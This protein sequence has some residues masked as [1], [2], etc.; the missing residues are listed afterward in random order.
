MFCVCFFVSQSVFAYE[1]ARRT[2]NYGAEQKR[3]DAIAPLGIPFSGFDFF[4]FFGV[5][6]EFNDNIVKSEVLVLDDF[7]THLSP[8]FNIASDWNRHQLA[9]NVKSDIAFY[10]EYSGQNYQ[11][12]TVDFNGRLD[13]LQNSALQFSTFFGSLHVSAQ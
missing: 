5:G 8:G 11:D 9:L 4:P 10:A 7:I 1:R 12:V 6:E 2:L 3:A 13:V